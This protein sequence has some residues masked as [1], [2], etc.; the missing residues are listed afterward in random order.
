MTTPFP[1]RAEQDGLIKP[2]QRG[3]KVHINTRSKTLTAEFE[4]SNNTYRRA[5]YESRI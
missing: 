3:T 1:M 2:I 5:T 4:L